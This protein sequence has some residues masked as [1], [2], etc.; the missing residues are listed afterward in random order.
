MLVGWPA[1]GPRIREVRRLRQCIGGLA[2]PA[3]QA[4]AGGRG[5]RRAAGALSAG[6][7]RHRR[8]RGRVADRRAAGPA[9]DDRA[10]AGRAGPLRPAWLCR[11][12]DAPAATAKD[13][14][15]VRGKVRRAVPL[16]TAD[17][18]LVPFSAAWGGSPITVIGLRVNAVRGG[19]GDNVSDIVTRLRGKHGGGDGA[20]SSG[21]SSSSR[22]RRAR[23]ERQ[24]LGAGLR[25]RPLAEDRRHRRVARARAS[26]LGA[27]ARRLRVDRARRRRQGARASAPT[28]LDVRTALALGAAP[29]GRIRRCAC[30]TDS[31]R[32]CRTLALTGITGVIAPPPTAAARRRTR[33]TRRGD[34][35]ARQLRR[36]ARG[37]L[38]GE[39]ARRSGERRRASCRCARSSSRWGKHR[40]RAAALGAVAGEHHAR[41]RVR[42]RPG[43]ATRSASAATWRSSA[44]QPAARRAGEP[45]RSRT[46]RSGSALRGDGLS[47]SAGGWSWS[48]LEARVR[49]LTARLTGHVALPRG[50]FRFTNG[51]QLS[52]VPKIDLHV[53]GAA[54]AVRQAARQ[55]PGGAGAQACRGSCCRGTSRR[56]RRREDRLRAIST[57]SICAARSASTAARW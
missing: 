14:G 25:E 9:G 44:C 49:D 54:R 40:R 53:H 47:A 52:V 11:D 22:A 24:R 2:A 1:S 55:H 39:G 27:A 10:G 57:R 26:G 3:S 56:R 17:E 36:R 46:C 21:S 31:R 33:R 28:E 32:R 7:R 34:R 12:G 51:S 50:K 16:V 30:R 5:R 48:V 23:R 41:R 18:I 37:A 42:S 43:W 8:A 35:S 15:Q 45:T 13:G 4:V 6:D 29:A 20:S 19:D 38:D